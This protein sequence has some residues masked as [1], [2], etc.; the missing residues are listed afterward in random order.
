MSDAVTY[1]GSEADQLAEAQR[2]LDT[3]VTSSATGR[4]L[5]CGALGPCYLRE[6]AVETWSR[7]IFRLPHR[8]P[9]ATRPEL[10]G[11]RQV[12]AGGSPLLPKAC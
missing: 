5:Q 11:A 2:T 1:Y 9:G 3:H 6:N 4:C 12:S 10:I 7:A 8:R